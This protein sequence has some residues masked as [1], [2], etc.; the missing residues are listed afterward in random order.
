MHI[1]RVLLA[2]LAGLPLLAQLAPQSQLAR[3]I[4]KELIEINTTDSNGDNTRAAEAVAA[5]LRAAG[6]RG[7]DVQVLVPAPRKGNLVARLRGKGQGR[8]V[9][10]IGHL[11]V[12]EARREDWS[13][14]PFTLIEKDAYFY[15]RGTQD[16]KGEDALL[17]ASFIRLKREGYVPD[18]D[19]ILA[20]TADEEGGE[21]NGVQWLLAHRR[22]LVDAEYCI[23]VDAGGGQIKNGKRELMS[24]SAAEKSFFHVRLTV[25]NPGGHSSLPVPENAIYRLAEGLVRLEKLRFPVFLNQV[26]RAYF[27][28]MGAIETGQTAADMKAIVEN[29]RNQAAA[30]RLGR[31]PYYNA[32]LRTTCVATELAG[33][34]AVNALPQTASA[35]VNCRLVP[36]DTQEN[37]ETAIRQV[38]ADPKIE[39]ARVYPTQANPLSPVAGEL[40]G[41]VEKVARQFWP[42]LPVVPVME[43]GGTDGRH[44]R[45]T[46][47]PTYGVAAIF[48]DMADIRA[49][50]KD[51]RISVEAFYQG[52]D[53]SYEMVKALGRK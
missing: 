16:I 50:G 34:H 17:V 39:M 52:A 20:L 3:G 11:D 43:T 48:N 2:L 30:E 32:L 37:V 7:A 29:P 42:G 22:D 47:I 9:L 49:H 28:R 19:L 4:L 38:L 31:S 25:R 23:N 46:G 6:Y 44:L 45:V 1:F 5:R 53:F 35:G 14:D 18:R 26:T 33:G 10:F 21:S 41:T 15:G 36:G 27:E 13:F 40:M 24:V 51:E 8:P 12:V